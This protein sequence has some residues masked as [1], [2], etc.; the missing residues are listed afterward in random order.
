MNPLDLPGWSD[1]STWGW[2]DGIGS[3]FAELIRDESDDPDEPEFW[4]SG[5]DPRFKTKEALARGIGIATRFQTAT[6]L[7]FMDD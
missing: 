7:S 6:V 3:Y 2:D 4:L 5:V 1:Y